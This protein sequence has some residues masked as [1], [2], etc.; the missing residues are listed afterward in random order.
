MARKVIEADPATYGDARSNMNSNFTELYVLSEDVAYPEMAGAK[1]DGVTDDTQA[2]KDAIATGK[3][4]RLYSGTYKITDELIMPD[5][6]EAIG[7]EDTVLLVDGVT[8]G[9][10]FK[11]DSSSNITLKNVKLQSEDNTS[12][13]GVRIIGDCNNLK[14]ENV[15]SEGF[16]HGIH[17][18]GSAGDAATVGRI[19]NSILLNCKATH[20]ATEI[21]TDG[22]YGILISDCDDVIV[23]NCETAYNWLDGIKVIKDNSSRVTIFKGVSHHNGQDTGSNGNGLDGFSGSNGLLID[24]L[25][26][27]DNNGSGIYIKTG[28]L[29]KQ[30][31]D[32]F[33]GQVRDITI[34]NTKNYKNTSSGIDINRA[35]GDAD[36]SIPLISGIYLDGNECSF[37]GEQ[38]MYVRA[39]DVVFGTNIC[40]GNQKHG[41]NLVSCENVQFAPQILKG[42][43]RSSI[44]QFSGISMENSTNVRVVNGILKGDNLYEDVS[45]QC[46][47]TSNSSTVNVSDSSTL[48]AGDKI[49]I[50]VSATGDV[51]TGVIDAEVESIPNGTSIVLKG[52]VTV[53]TDSTYGIFKE[54]N[55]KAKIS[56]YGIYVASDSDLVEIFKPD[57]SNTSNATLIGTGKTSGTLI[58][59]WG[60]HH[61]D[62]AIGGQGSTLIYN[63]DIYHKTS[64]NPNGYSD[65]EW[66]VPIYA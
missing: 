14:L 49:D 57:I 46:G 30:F 51:G 20:L 12:S 15:R 37:N 47:I 2:F 29:S 35:G 43:G 52:G 16:G 40:I 19:T 8:V 60:K 63:N 13:F 6:Y 53:T 18:N 24:G 36:L 27:H 38:G 50:L 58:I 32:P 28:D 56:K 21:P 10:V 7:K 65:T 62:F 48:N 33:Y 34:K 4:L 22:D 3:P 59:D 5:D 17:L 42:N 41:I 64:G 44:G 54:T 66:Q 31:N 9:G 23:N 61:Q 45:V 11:I 1:R 55:T 26:T 39:K 25:V